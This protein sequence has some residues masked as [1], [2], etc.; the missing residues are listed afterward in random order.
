MP[1]IK[2]PLPVIIG[3]DVA[4]EVVKIRRGLHDADHGDDE[5]ES[6][7]LA[8][9]VGRRQGRK[10]HVRQLNGQRAQR[11]HAPSLEVEQ[12]HNDARP[13]RA[14]QRPWDLGTD[15]GR[16]QG[17]DEHAR[18]ERKRIRIGLPQAPKDTKQTQQKMSLLRLC[19]AA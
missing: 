2:I 12:R 8:E 19:S 3:L 14:N 13:A 1:G 7:Q 17:Y 5:G 16:A 6:H 10:R 18:A 4:G 15:P 11:A 9:F